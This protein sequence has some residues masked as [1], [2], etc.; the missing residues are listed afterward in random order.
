MISAVSLAF[1]VFV[2][3]PNEI[4]VSPDVAKTTSETS[5][6]NEETS[7]NGDIE[8]QKPLVNPPKIIKA[9]YATG[10]SAG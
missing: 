8:N 10:W 1:F 9:I 4:F 5:S 6:A 3:K 2:N 7:K